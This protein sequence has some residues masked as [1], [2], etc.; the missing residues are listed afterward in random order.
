VEP[1]SYTR[2]PARNLVSLRQLKALV[3]RHPQ[4]QVRLGHQA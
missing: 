1:G 2:D 3:A 4:I